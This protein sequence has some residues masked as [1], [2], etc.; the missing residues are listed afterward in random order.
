ML[1]ATDLMG[2]CTGAIPY[3]GASAVITTRTGNIC[4]T[5]GPNA[6]NTVWSMV[7]DGEAGANKGYSQA[8]YFRF[9][10]QPTAYFA[11]YSVQGGGFF[12]RTVRND[13][14]PVA[15]GSNHRY[16]VQYVPEC[17]CFR[18]N[19][20]ATILQVTPFGPY[21]A[22]QQPFELQWFGETIHEAS[23]IPGTNGTRTPLYA[24]EVQ[25]ESDNQFK[26]QVP[27]DLTSVIS[28]ARYRQT[29]F[30]YANRSF[31]IWTG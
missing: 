12:S 22:W 7:A 28:S 14:G 1:K 3:R 13:L 18:N 6:F 17:I 4:D 23:N 20:D 31:Q 27:P 15:L 9:V 19:V 11:E 5:A 21:G 24:L 29:P 30:D 2:T 10:N 16:W 8:G 25:W 26:Q